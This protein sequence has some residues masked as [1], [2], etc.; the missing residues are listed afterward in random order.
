MVKNIFVG[1]I[2]S[3]EGLEKYGKE[4]GMRETVRQCDLSKDNDR[5]W[6]RGG[7][8]GQAIGYPLWAQ[9]MEMGRPLGGG[10]LTAWNL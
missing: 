5:R 8:Q 3:R 7:A 2:G 10:G 9:A 6:H 4:R 1:K